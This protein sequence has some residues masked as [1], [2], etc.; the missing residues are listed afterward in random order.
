MAPSLF[1]KTKQKPQ[2]HGKRKTPPVILF[3]PTFYFYVS[4]FSKIRGKH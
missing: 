2:Q 1:T 3:A 4:I